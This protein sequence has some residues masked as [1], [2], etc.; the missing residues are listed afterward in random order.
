MIFYISKI[1]TSFLLP[2]G[3]FIAALF[4]SAFYAK[5]YKK[6]FLGFAIVFLIFSIR[7]F[8]NL[9]LSPL[10]EPYTKPFVKNKNAKAVVVL[11]G[12]SLIDSPNLPLYPGSL[13]R[14]IYGIMIA[15]KENLP[16]IY[17]GAD[18]LKKEKQEKAIRQT[19]KELQKSLNLSLP[20]KNKIENRFC[21]VIEKYSLNTYQNALFTKKLFEKNGFK[22]PSIYLVTSAYH[23][24]R[25]ELLFKRMGF[26]VTPEATDFQLNKDINYA[27]F[28]PT[29]NALT[30]S[31]LALHEYFGIIKELIFTN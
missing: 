16:L 1:F 3:I 24:K 8:S 17:T 30:T 11:A 23:M 10:E 27:Y 9:L 29:F 28:L 2:P 25:S 26:L 15:K 22:N 14:L 12:G 5:K 13:K 31:F 6:L 21:I 18:T 20:I 7:A 19:I 4:L